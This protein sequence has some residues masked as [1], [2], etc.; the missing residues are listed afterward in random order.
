MIDIWNSDQ[1]EW[2]REPYLFIMFNTHI[3]VVVVYSLV[4]IIV[5]YTQGGAC[6]APQV[7]CYQCELCVCRKIFPLASNSEL[8]AQYTQFWLV[9]PRCPLGVI[10]CVCRD[11][12]MT[13]NLAITLNISPIQHLVM[14]SLSSTTDTDIQQYATIHMNYVLA[15]FCTKLVELHF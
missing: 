7:I 8:L 10:A 5:R 9:A 15:Q 11:T 14:S 4:L 13:G 1:S 3:I 6:L 12:L 2:A